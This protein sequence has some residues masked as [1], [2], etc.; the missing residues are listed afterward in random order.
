[1]G[2]V[3]GG[4]SALCAVAVLVVPATACAQEEG[5]GTMTTSSITD[6]A[7]TPFLEIRPSAA[8]IMPPRAIVKGRRELLSEPACSVP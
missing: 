7:G 6:V 5:E 1:M 8:G 2:V 4:L 3:R